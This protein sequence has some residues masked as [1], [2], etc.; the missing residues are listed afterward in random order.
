MLNVYELLTYAAFII[1]TSY[2]VVYRMYNIM[3]WNRTET[4][5]PPMF[6]FMLHVSPSHRALPKRCQRELCL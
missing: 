2:F 1:A 4:K 3:S 5:M 6:N